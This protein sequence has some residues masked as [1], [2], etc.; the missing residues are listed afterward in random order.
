MEKE[1]LAENFNA[2]FEE[3]SESNKNY[4]I[5]ILQAL[6]FSQKAVET[7]KGT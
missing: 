2:K 4:I 3:L 6:M 1:V 5:A 7:N